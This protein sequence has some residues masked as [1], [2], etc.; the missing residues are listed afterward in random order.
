MNQT[1]FLRKLATLKGKFKLV[2]N[3]IRSKRKRKV[4]IN[5]HY[6][7][8]L[9]SNPREICPIEYVHAVETEKMPFD[10]ITAARDMK[11]SDDLRRC[12][13][14]AADNN[15][16]YCLEWTNIAQMRLKMLKVLALEE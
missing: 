15:L 11:I 5:G 7:P 1:T 13:S 4:V 10:F 6:N 14:V 9:T 2:S 16:A 12:I 8:K 3:Q